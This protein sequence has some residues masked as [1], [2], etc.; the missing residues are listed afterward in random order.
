MML[1]IIA[2]DWLYEYSRRFYIRSIHKNLKPLNWIMLRGLIGS[3]PSWGLALKMNYLYEQ[4][5]TLPHEGDRTH[6]QYPR[7]KVHAFLPSHMHYFIIL[8][9]ESFKFIPLLWNVAV[10]S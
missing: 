2:L 3:Y 9:F 4:Y 6:K 10:S 7:G 5:L 1:S 8:I